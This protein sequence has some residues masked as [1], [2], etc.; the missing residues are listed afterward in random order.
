[1]SNYTLDQKSVVDSM[2]AVNT[3][4]KVQRKLHTAI[5]KGS[6]LEK[7]MDFAFSIPDF[8]RIVKGNHRHELGDI[9]ILMILARMSK[10]VGCADIIE[11]GRHNLRKFQSMGLLGNDVPSV[12]TL[13]RVDNGIDELGFAGQMGQQSYGG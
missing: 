3:G 5:P 10:C 2:S 4:T 8:R 13:C 1:M 7:L 6:I 9:I 12:A 11:F